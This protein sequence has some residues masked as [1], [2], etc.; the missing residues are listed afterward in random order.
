[1][2]IA[3][4]DFDFTK[5]YYLAGPMTGIPEFN[6]PAFSLSKSELEAAGIAVK[7]PHEI[8]WPESPL[9]S[10]EELWQSM[11]KRALNML[12][13]C[14]GIILMRGWVRSRGALVEFNVAAALKMPV[15]MMDGKYLVPIHEAGAN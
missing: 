3:D 14:E 6:Y 2:R 5:T 15:Y 8:P 11:M 7:S 13:E 1:M 4:K 10:N 9:G 12:L